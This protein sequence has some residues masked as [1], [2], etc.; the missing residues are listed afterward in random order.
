MRK[1][2]V[3]RAAGAGPNAHCVDI[4]HRRDKVRA[5]SQNGPLNCSPRLPDKNHGLLFPSDG[6]QYRPPPT[7]TRTIGATSRDTAHEIRSARASHR[8]PSRGQLQP[9]RPGRQPGIGPAQ[10]ADRRLPYRIRATW[11]GSRSIWP[12][13]PIPPVLRPWRSRSQRS[14]SRHARTHAVVFPAISAGCRLLFRTGGAAVLRFAI[15]ARPSDFRTS[16]AEIHPEC[17]SALAARTDAAIYVDT[18]GGPRAH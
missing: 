6:S 18:L 7:H 16:G 5:R 3:S 2:V 12:E 15:C 11:R 8:F 10:L 17:P 4:P 9:R 13:T 14:Q 1:A